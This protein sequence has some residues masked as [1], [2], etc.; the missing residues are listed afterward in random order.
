MTA[1][2]PK[3]KIVKKQTDDAA[4]MLRWLNG[5]LREGELSS[6][7]NKEEYE[8]M[9][10][11][12]QNNDRHLSSELPPLNLLDKQKKASTTTTA[13]SSTFVTFAFVAVAILL[14]ALFVFKFNW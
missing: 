3:K 5:T 14:L 12:A 4:F 7:R 8:E 2:L 10:T 9:M 6:L 11:M 13:D 1:Q